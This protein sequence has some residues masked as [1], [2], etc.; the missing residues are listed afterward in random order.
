MNDFDASV[1][2]I[3]TLSKV[4]GGFSST[5]AMCVSPCPCRNASGAM[6]RSTMISISQLIEARANVSK[7]LS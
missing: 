1:K 5:E 7:H 6:V 2:K 4:W 3:K